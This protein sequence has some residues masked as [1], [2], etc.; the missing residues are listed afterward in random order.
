MSD[1]FG[2]VVKSKR[3]EMSLTQMRLAELVGRSSSTIRSWERGQSVP[4]DLEVY[5]ALSAV[6]GVGLV[7]LVE[8]AGLEVDPADLA[9]ADRNASRANISQPDETAREASTEAEAPIEVP[10]AISAEAKDPDADRPATLFEASPLDDAPDGDFGSDDP[11]VIA[12]VDSADDSAEDPVFD[13]NS[14]EVPE[15]AEATEEAP[16]EE[17]ILGIATAS[18]VEYLAEPRIVDVPQPIVVANEPLVLDE[19]AQIPPTQRPT[20]TAP[21]ARVAQSPSPTAVQSRPIGPN[22]YLD[23]PKAIMA[24]RIRAG[25]TV[26]TLIVMALLGRWAWAGFR[27]QMG[28]ILDGFT[29]GF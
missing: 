20:A 19:T 16:P 18:D 1:T 25:L 7:D 6:L 21:A 22:S 11:T 5:E 26:A 27:E 9:D 14:V 29:T 24:Y 4:N 13:E 10:V 12:M 23:D 3:I 28:N 2:Q 8:T 15:V 17:R